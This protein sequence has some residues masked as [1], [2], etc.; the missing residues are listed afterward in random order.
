MRNHCS[1]KLYDLEKALRPYGASI[2]VPQNAFSEMNRNFTSQ[3]TA[4]TKGRVAFVSNNQLGEPGSGIYV[5]KGY[6]AR[7]VVTFKMIR[8]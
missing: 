5:V 8:K 4:D 1:F 2:A 3:Y 6:K 7:E